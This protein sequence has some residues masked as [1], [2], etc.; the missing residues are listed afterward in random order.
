MYGN[1]NDPT[2][3]I[4]GK[5]LATDTCMVLADGLSTCAQYGQYIESSRTVLPHF[6]QLEAIKITYKTIL[7]NESF[8]ES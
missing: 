5:L 7:A 8:L 4:T 1:M 2:V 3:A 6:G